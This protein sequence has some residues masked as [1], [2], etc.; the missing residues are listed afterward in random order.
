MVAAV[1][2]WATVVRAENVEGVVPHALGFQLG[3]DVANDSVEKIHH[4]LVGGSAVKE[5]AHPTG[6]SEQPLSL[7]VS[8]WQLDG[9]VRDVEVVVEEEWGG[10]VVAV[11]QGEGLCL[12]LGGLEGGHAAVDPPGEDGAGVAPER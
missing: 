9:L 5:I 4:A 1:E 11:D 2:A 3:R 8:A 10:G 12:K 6:S 7:E